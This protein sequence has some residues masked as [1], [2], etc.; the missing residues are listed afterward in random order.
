MQYINDENL[1]T[2]L[3]SDQKKIVLYV[4]SDHQQHSIHNSLS[5]IYIKVQGD[6]Y[7]STFDH[8]DYPTQSSEDLC[9][10]NAYTINIKD[11]INLGV[12]VTNSIDLLYFHNAPSLSELQHFYQIKLGNVKNINNVIPVYAHLEYM[13]KLVQLLKFDGNYI[14]HSD[15]YYTMY[16]HMMPSVFSQ[17]ERRGVPVNPEV[18]THHYG[19]DKRHLIRENRVYTSYNLYTTTGR[20]SNTHGGINYAA[21]NKSD[22]SRQ[23]YASDKLLV[24]VDF[25]SYHLHLICEKLGMEIPDDLH[26]WL[27]KQYFDTDHLTNDQY[28]EA[29]KIT[30]KNLYGYQLEERAKHIDLFKQ[31]QQF[32]ETLWTQY[33]QSGFLLTDYD[34]VITVENASKNKVFNYYMQAL[35]TETNVKQLYYLIGNN[36]TPFL[37]TYDSMGFELDPSDA[38]RTRNILKDKLLYPYT[39]NVGHDLEF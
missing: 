3:K 11:L 18:F 4:M 13:K 29:K 35:E 14:V 2:I 28:E 25:N 21:L 20:P 34:N 12:V 8:P 26:S 23:A 33:Q 38:R 5:C 6:E 19:E 24:N 31:V 1:R 22:G 37:Y 36:L 32:Q 9:I 10:N 39:V 16:H 15:R 7:Y 30:F 27:G 17:I